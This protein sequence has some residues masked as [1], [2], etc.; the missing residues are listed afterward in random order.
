[1]TAKNIPETG[2]VFNG[3][4][5]A[6]RELL[7]VTFGAGDTTVDVV[8]GDT[9]EYILVS[10]T[11]PIVV[12]GLHTQV[13]TAFTASVTATVGDSSTIA[14]FIADTTMAPAST[15]AV[16]V[17]ATG[18]SVPYVYAAAQDIK[19]GIAGATAAAGVAHVYLEY[20]VLA[21]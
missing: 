10:V 18:L 17:A 1:M 20:A 7:H 3:Y 14:R 12:F 5:P 4:V 21:D 8:V 9:G 6:K 19:V 13:E 16:L 11:E 15:G 2:Q